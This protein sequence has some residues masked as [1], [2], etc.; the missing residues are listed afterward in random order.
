MNEKWVEF[1]R[2][3]EPSNVTDHRVYSH[4][5][6]GTR[7]DLAWVPLTFFLRTSGHWLSLPWFSRSLSRWLV[8]EKAFNVHEPRG[9]TELQEPIFYFILQTLFGLLTFLERKMAEIRRNCSCWLS[10]VTSKAYMAY[11][12]WKVTLRT[13]PFAKRRSRWRKIKK[14]SCLFVDFFL[15][16]FVGRLTRDKVLKTLALMR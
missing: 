5:K 13:R 12:V 11:G 10:F 16:P 4:R 15:I 2:D 9:E 3:P 7:C 14:V 1:Y 8:P 6:K